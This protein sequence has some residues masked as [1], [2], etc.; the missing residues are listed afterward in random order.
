MALAAAPA[1]NRFDSQQGQT[2]A[3]PSSVTNTPA[4]PASVAP[5]SGPDQR[6][7]G[8]AISG[9]QDAGIFSPLGSPL[10]RAAIRRNALRSAYNQRQRG[11]VLSR[12]LGLNPNEARAQDLQTEGDAG[13]TAADSINQGDLQMLAGNQEFLRSLF[14]GQ[15]SAENQRDLARLMA[16]LQPRTTAGGAIGSI[17]GTGA[18]AYFGGLGTAAGT[19]LGHP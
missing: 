9:A 2:P 5:F 11:S 1:L 13:N 14:T 6:I 3:M 19:A 8:Q 17:V 7:A 15:L 10:L 4:A 18:G 12:L 16:A